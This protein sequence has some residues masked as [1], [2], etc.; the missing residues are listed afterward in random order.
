MS[1]ALGVLVVGAGGWA[2]VLNLQVPVPLAGQD[3]R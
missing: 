1:M 3:P 2:R